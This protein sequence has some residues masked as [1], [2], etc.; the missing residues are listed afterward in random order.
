L[1][2]ALAGCGQGSDAANLASQEFI[3][4]RGQALAWLRADLAA[5]QIL[6]K[7]EPGQARITVQK[8]MRHWQQDTISP[9]SAATKPWPNCRRPNARS[10]GSYGRRPRNWRDVP[11]QP[12]RLRAG[13]NEEVRAN[14]GVRWLDTAFFLWRLGASKTKERKKK[15]VSSHALQR[16]SPPGNETNRMMR[17]GELPFRLLFE[18]S[19]LQPRLF[20]VL[21]GGVSGRQ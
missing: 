20:A 15:A 3:R 17:D 8:A 5:W 2:S 16:G 21:N 19:L 1:R 4:L 7:K 18:Q 14:F 9:A 11:V 12:T 6:L 10:G 13:T